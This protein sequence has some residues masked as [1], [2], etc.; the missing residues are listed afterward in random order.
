MTSQPRAGTH[1][2]NEIFHRLR[3]I[4]KLK[5][6]IW[7]CACNCAWRFHVP[8]QA[9]HIIHKKNI[10][11]QYIQADYTLFRHI[12][13]TTHPSIYWYTT[14]DSMDYY[15][16][17][18]YKSLNDSMT[19]IQFRDELAYVISKLDCGHTSYERFKSI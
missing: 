13:E 4:R 15:F 2:P 6:N 3:M 14:K 1:L 7:I 8:L 9:N 12:L 18:V 11:L 10:R 19:E 16:E 5:T 17:K